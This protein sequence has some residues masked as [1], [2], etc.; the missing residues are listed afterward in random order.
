M[1]GQ[2]HSFAMLKVFG[3]LDSLMKHRVILFASIFVL[4]LHECAV[5]TRILNV[6]NMKKIQKTDGCDCSDID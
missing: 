6:E 4:S 3:T 5:M 2:I 1:R